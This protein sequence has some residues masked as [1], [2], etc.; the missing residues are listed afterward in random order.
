MATKTVRVEAR[1]TPEIKQLAERAAAISGL[2]LTDY[3]AQLVKNDAPQ[4]IESYK[5]I[6]LTNR[7]FDDFIAYCDSNP[8]PSPRLAQ[9]FE[10]LQSEGF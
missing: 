6:Q 5:N 9:A 2:S 10:R 8:A 1:L 3:L 7:E 4:T